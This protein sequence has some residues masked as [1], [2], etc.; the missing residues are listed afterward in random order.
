MFGRWFN[1]TVL[2][3]VDKMTHRGM[4]LKPRGR[5]DVIHLKSI[6][7]RTGVDSSA[8]SVRDFGREHHHL[9]TAHERPSVIM[10]KDNG[11]AANPAQG[12]ITFVKYTSCN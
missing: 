3:R 4:V 8:S 5:I 6:I 1:V 7:V 9:D 2:S 10:A 11:S 12:T